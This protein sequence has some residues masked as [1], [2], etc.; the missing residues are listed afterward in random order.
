MSKSHVG[1]YQRVINFL[2]YLFVFS[3]CFER[4]TVF[5]QNFDFVLT[6]ISSSLLILFSFFD[7]N[8]WKS[9]NRIAYYLFLL[10]IFFLIHTFS[11]YVNKTQ[12][13]N[14]YF[15][16][17]FF[18]NIL[19][20]SV[21]GSNFNRDEKLVSK[22]FFI[23]FVGN[24]ILTFLYFLGIG[25]TDLSLELEGR[26]S[27]FGNNQNYLGLSLSLSSLY[28]LYN[29]FFCEKSKLTFYLYII[30]ILPITYF[31]FLTGSR[32]AFLLFVLGI[33]ILVLLSKGIRKMYKILFFIFFSIIT[34]QLL[35]FFRDKLD[36]FQRLTAT[37]ED[38]DSANRDII[39]SGL[40]YF[41]SDFIFLGVGK[42]G[43]LRMV[44]DLSP[45]NAFL[46]I[47]IYT[48]IIGL[49]I[50]IIFLT[51]LFRNILRL[52][53]NTNN[54]FPIVIYI[55]VFGILVTGQLFD[56]KV[57]WY[58]LACLIQHPGYKSKVNE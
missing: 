3:I 55:G 18:L 37:L 36:I 17:L 6:K 1:L 23:F 4:I 43:Y 9:L 14:E 24:V 50:F 27:I 28:I 19:I 15:D 56:Q 48:G 33:L 8:F 22:T 42:T 51:S 58:F 12:A 11:N 16:Y 49:S 53:S 39:W 13:Y 57:I 52:N 5:G 38:G 32:T 41:F 35:I 29:L 54:F 7:L 45:H 46:E 21:L 47:L 20:F 40:L 2:L 31:M 34:I 44:G 10:L 25:Q 30:S 26:A